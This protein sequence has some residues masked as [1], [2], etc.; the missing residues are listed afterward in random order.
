MRDVATF[1]I[2]GNVAQLFLQPVLVGE[3]VVLVD[4]VRRDAHD[5]AGAPGQ[6]DQPLVADDD[7]GILAILLRVPERH[8]IGMPEHGVRLK[9][10]LAA[11]DDAADQ[12]RHV[13]L[14]ERRHARNAGDRHAHQTFRVHVARERLGDNLLVL[15]Q[16]VLHLL[17]GL[18]RRQLLP[19]DAH[20]LRRRVR[21][22]LLVCSLDVHSALSPL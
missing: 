4:R 22:F 16:Q 6:V 8:E 9:P 3:L 19:G 7:L 20:E 12:G 13:A 17:L 2:S 10:H 21:A 15:L 14:Q 5:L 1:A 11:L 18:E